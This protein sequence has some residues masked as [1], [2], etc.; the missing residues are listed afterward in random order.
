MNC[1]IKIFHISVSSSELFLG[2]FK[3]LI[4]FFSFFYSFSFS[5]IFSVN[6][7]SIIMCF[8]MFLVFLYVSLSLLILLNSF[9]SIRPNF[10]N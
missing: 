5:F 1:Y 7:L 9:V 8:D 4:I 3:L 2:F 6:F 10:H